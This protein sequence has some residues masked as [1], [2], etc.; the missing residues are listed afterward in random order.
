MTKKRILLFFFPSFSE[1]NV[2]NFSLVRYPQPN[3]LEVRPIRFIS[4]QESKMVRSEREKRFSIEFFFGFSSAIF[5]EFNETNGK[6]RN[7]IRSRV[8]NLKDSKNPELRINVLLGG[9]T[10]ERLAVLTSEVMSI[11]CGNELSLT[12]TLNFFRKWRVKN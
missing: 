11:G 9:I 3:Y 4:L 6:Y 12:L 10:P 5:K 1:S 7:R 8:S 2:A